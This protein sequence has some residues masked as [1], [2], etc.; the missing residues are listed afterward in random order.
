V[1]SVSI[2]RLIGTRMTRKNA[3]FRGFFL[4]LVR[5][6]SPDKTGA[7]AVSKMEVSIIAKNPARDFLP[8]DTSVF[9]RIIAKKRF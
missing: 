2:R 5:C 6:F 1:F 8:M 3:D 4:A 7:E 9:E